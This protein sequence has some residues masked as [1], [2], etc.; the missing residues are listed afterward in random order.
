MTQ[1]L[2]E[3]YLCI[4][5]PMGCRLEVDE[6]IE[7]HAIVEVRGFSCRRGREYALQEH[8]DPRR[9]VTTTVAIDQA[10]WRRL[11]VRSEIAAPK[12]K[13]IAICRA[14][15]SVRVSAPVAMG[16]IIVSDILGTGVNIIAARDM[17]KI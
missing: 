17:R 15:R 11:P 10:R 3:H 16:D 6:D 4:G 13:G 5:C 7:S 1:R 8:T 2:T 14:L 12:G 9:I